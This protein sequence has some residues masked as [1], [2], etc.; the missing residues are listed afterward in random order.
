MVGEGGV[1]DVRDFD[2]MWKFIDGQS[3]SQSIRE[4][5]ESQRKKIQA[6]DMATTHHL[7]WFFCTERLLNDCNTRSL[8]VTQL[9][10]IK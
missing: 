7:T 4:Q 5:G 2:S 6:L 1:G 10:L 9:S 3:T 8:K